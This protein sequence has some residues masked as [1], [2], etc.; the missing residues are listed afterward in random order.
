MVTLRRL[1]TTIIFGITI[2]LAQSVIAQVIVLD[3]NGT[4]LGALVSAYPSS[5]PQYARP[6]PYEQ[7]IS[8]GSSTY[9]II[10]EKN[11]QFTLGWPRTVIGTSEVLPN[12]FLGSVGNSG[13]LYESS[14]C[15]GQAFVATRQSGI[16]FSI[17]NLRGQDESQSVY[18]VPVNEELK[19]RSFLSR[20]QGDTLDECVLFDE[21]YNFSGRAYLN[22]PAETGFTDPT[23]PLPLQLRS[24]IDPAL[25]Q[26]V[27]RDGFEC[28]G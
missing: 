2:G 16:V 24:S 26:C 18:Y 11:Y 10:N 9:W 8:S 4:G 12:A 22:S 25:A 15:T 14:D 27:F 6:V 13:L 17:T 3:G 1:L 7:T 20:L 28:E 19:N 21:T 5:G 23:P